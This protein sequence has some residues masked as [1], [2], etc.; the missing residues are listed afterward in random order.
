MAAT[1]AAVKT[2]GDF[3]MAEGLDLCVKSNSPA[4]AI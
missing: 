4:I 1:A 3:F 2:D